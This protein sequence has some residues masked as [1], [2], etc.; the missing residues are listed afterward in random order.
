[1][2]LRGDDGGGRGAHS[3]HRDCRDRYYPGYYPGYCGGYGYPDYDYDGYCDGYGGATSPTAK[4]LQR[5]AAALNAEVRLVAKT[6]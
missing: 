6:A 2:P 1:V 4:T 5:I 3:H